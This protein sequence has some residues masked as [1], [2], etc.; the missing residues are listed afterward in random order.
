MLP[1]R[2]GGPELGRQQH[3]AGRR[4]TLALAHTKASASRQATRAELLRILCSTLAVT[5]TVTPIIHQ[6]FFFMGNS[7]F[8]HSCSIW[9]L[10]GLGAS[11]KEQRGL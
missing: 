7:P 4:D 2:M 11:P 9:T 8:R 3:A 10:H 1:Y 5:I 6:G